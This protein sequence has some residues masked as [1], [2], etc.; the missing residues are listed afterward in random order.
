[1]DQA[2][3][4]R[5]RED[6]DF[7]VIAVGAQK[8]RRLPV[9]GGEKMITALDFLRQAKARKIKPGR[10]VVIIGAGNVGCDVATE[11]HRL[12][13]EE[14]TLI[15]IQE[16][17]SFGK[18]RA[19]AEAAGAQFL[20]PRF[21]KR[22]TAEGVE[23]TSGEMLA[24][25]TVVISIGDEPDLDFLPPEVAVEKGFIR[26]NE[27]NQTTDAK[28]FAIGDA[29]RPGLLTDAIGSGRKVA[30]A[31]AEIVEGKRPLGD[32]R[33]MIDRRRVHLEYFDPRITEFE[34]TAHCGSQCSSCGAC[35]DCG[36]CIAVC[37]YSA[38]SRV[39]LDEDD[40]EYVVDD[41]RCI[42]CGFCAGACP[43]GI[44]NLIE[45]TPRE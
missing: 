43:C 27:H 24:A 17:A 35:R 9:P 38:I 34:D 22:I 40:Y 23:L 19:D 25:D 31:I 7:V 41:N 3:F 10:R 2:E 5:L 37:P 32:T 26:T 21:T 8:P 33:R 13:A 16:P 42:G 30:L 28:V 1:M 36:V 45:N 39:A 29:V 18:E 4:E 20:W 6:F 14:L 12:G 44:W 11:A 15:D